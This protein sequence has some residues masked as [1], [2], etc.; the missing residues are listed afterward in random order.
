MERETPLN[1]PLSLLSNFPTNS[2]QFEQIYYLCVAQ[3]APST[4]STNA[5][6]MMMKKAASVSLPKAKIESTALDKPYNKQV[7]TID[8]ITTHKTEPY[9]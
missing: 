4:P 2:V 5:F 1:A 9:H 3:E 8:P 6:Q 7:I